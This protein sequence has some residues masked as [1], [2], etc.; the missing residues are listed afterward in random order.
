[1]S[2][3]SDPN[4]LMKAV[5][6]LMDELD[7][8]ASKSETTSDELFER[9]NETLAAV[10]QP[11]ASAIFIFGPDGIPCNANR[12]EPIESYFPDWIAAVNDVETSA[13]RFVKRDLKKLT[14]L[15]F[16]LSHAS[17]SN[18]VLAGLL[19]AKIEKAEDSGATRSLLQ[20]IADLISRFISGQLNQS[21]T[22]SGDFLSRVNDF[23]LSCMSTLDE[24]ELTKI[25]AN[26]ARMLME[27]ERVQLFKNA[28]N[29]LSLKA[30]SSVAV[31][32]RRTALL[33]CSARIAKQAC[34]QR[35]PILSSQAATD[36]QVQTSIDEYRELS[37]MPFFAFFPLLAKNRRNRKSTHPCGVLLAEFANQPRFFEFV[38]AANIVVPQSSMA[39]SNVQKISSIPFHHAL[40]VLANSLNLKGLSRLLLYFVLP[41]TLLFLAFL[42]P[43]DFKVRMTGTLRPV[44]EQLVFSPHD[45]FVDNVKVQYGEQVAKGQLL[46]ELR[47]PALNLELDEAIGEIQKLSKFKAAKNIAIN[48]ASTSDSGDRSLQAKLASEV[49]DLQFQISSFEDKRDYTL[50]RIEE[51]KIYSPIA[52]RIVTWNVNKLL[53]EKPVRWGDPLIRIADE[54][55]D[56]ELRFKASEKK[57]GY[58]NSAADDNGLT[59]LNVEYF[60]QSNPD[61]KFSTTIATAS[62]STE[63]DAEIGPSV[64]V[65]CDIDPSQALKRHGA[66]V[67]GDV[68]CGRRSIAYV[69]S[70]ELMDAIRRRFV[71]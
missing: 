30:V 15:G 56:W 63:V 38:R 21:E 7:Q 55:G 64:A 35:T 22:T 14:S 29:R 65:N 41:L 37:G 40:I 4:E 70:Y 33:R 3:S 24:R 45:A 47:S 43:A 11:E 13:E 51:L 61:L 27:C 25:I 36:K 59:G 34:R 10:L 17:G 71:W 52:G 23:S 6:S 50:R 8:L 19:V 42:I 9:V 69:W 26:D 32:E 49:A 28:S 20:A 48:Q 57:I 1:M 53:R 39:I 66:K 62:D 46:A 44:T 60:F 16:A 54:E 68:F 58:I 5:D 12:P 31:F 2:V 18:S 67:T